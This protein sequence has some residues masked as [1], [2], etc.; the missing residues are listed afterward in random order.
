MEL[1]KEHFRHVLLFYFNQKK[2][3]AESHRILVDTYG[4]TVPT[5]S[6]CEYWFRRFKSGDFDVSDKERSGQPKRFDDKTLQ[7][8]L[9]INSARTLKEL[10]AELN[11]TP[12]AVSKRLHSMGKIQKDG[13]WN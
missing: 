8:L 6:T 10:A 4:E 3:A 5:K 11:V 2:C 9:D 1:T 7:A 12:M 13:V